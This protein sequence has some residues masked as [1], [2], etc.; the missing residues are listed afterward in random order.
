VTGRLHSERRSLRRKPVKLNY[1]TIKESNSHR[2][3]DLSHSKAIVI[4]LD[5]GSGVNDS[6]IMKARAVY[7]Q[8]QEVYYACWTSFR[9][10][11]IT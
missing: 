11:V 10:K 6:V 3:E 8:S 5:G 1:I 2:E 7:N 4:I 9:T